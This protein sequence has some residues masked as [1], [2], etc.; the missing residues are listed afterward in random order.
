MP[1]YQD[2]GAV[3]EELKKNLERYFTN[4]GGRTF[5]IRGL[6][7]ELTGGALARYSR[8]RTGIQLTL[9]NEFL[10]EHGEPSQ[11]KGSA[12]MDRVLNAFGDDSV[13]ELEGV[14]VGLEDI[15][16]L[17]TKEIE[18]RRI[19]GSP[20]EQSTRYVVYDQKDRQGKWRYLR[21]REIM[22][23]GLGQRYEEVNDKAFEVYSEGVGLLRDYFKKQFP[24]DKFQIEVE[25]D[26]KKV[27]VYEK[28][29]S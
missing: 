6:P 5:V 14:H 18:D 21:P 1:R 17:L 29:L 10:D 12:L 7:S 25:R 4:V 28:D 23:S 11:Q 13:G 9:I 8:A 16:Q 15:S 27:K 19:G 3:P 22:E 20:I 26:G 2:F 24:R